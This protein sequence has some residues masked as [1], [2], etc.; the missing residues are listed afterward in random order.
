L[1]LQVSLHHSLTKFDILLSSIS[2]V[3]NGS[4]RLDALEN[5][6]NRKGLASIG[7]R[8]HQSLR[9]EISID[10]AAAPTFSASHRESGTSTTFATRS[11]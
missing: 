11:A 10:D 8:N 7:R 5:R 6:A 3:C 4:T 2:D 9:F 1:A